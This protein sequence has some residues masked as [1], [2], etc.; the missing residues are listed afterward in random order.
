MLHP[1]FAQRRSGK[2]FTY[3][4]IEPGQ[5]LF[6]TAALLLCRTV[7]TGGKQQLDLAQFVADFAKFLGFSGLAL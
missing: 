7:F 4:I 3:T 6:C 1:H 2:Y 5:F